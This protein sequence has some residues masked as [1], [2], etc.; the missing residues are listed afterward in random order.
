MLSCVKVLFE[1]HEGFCG[2]NSI[3]HT[4][5]QSGDQS[6]LRRFVITMAED[7]DYFFVLYITGFCAEGWLAVLALLHYPSDEHLE[8]LP[9][10]PDML[11]YEVACH[12][13][14]LSQVCLQSHTSDSK[15]T[16]TAGHS[17]P[18]LLVCHIEPSNR[19]SAGLLTN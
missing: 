11:A 6:E 13:V 17:S 7:Y 12:S 1:V 4:V 10:D 19:M 16:S 5:C 3:A 2:P 15:V 8:A 14:K 9:D 18:F